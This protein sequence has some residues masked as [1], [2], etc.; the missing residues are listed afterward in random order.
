M[1]GIGSSEP[2][3]DPIQHNTTVLHN[4]EVVRSSVEGVAR[5]KQH[6]ADFTKAQHKKF[7]IDKING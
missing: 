4:I 5:S 2:L 3:P 1:Q 6:C 7:Y